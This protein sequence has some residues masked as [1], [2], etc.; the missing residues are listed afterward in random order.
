[1]GWGRSP[2]SPTE[3]VRSQTFLGTSLEPSSA[4]VD[5]DEVERELAARGYSGFERH[6]GGAVISELSGTWLAWEIPRSGKLAPENFPLRWRV[7]E[8][9]PFGHITPADPSYAPDDVLAIGRKH[10]LD[11][12]IVSVGP[13]WVRI[14]LCDQSV[15]P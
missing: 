1:M 2:A 14:A 6:G 8:W 12:V 5:W 7:V 3:P 13:D 9:L 15:E 11:V 10:G 4:V